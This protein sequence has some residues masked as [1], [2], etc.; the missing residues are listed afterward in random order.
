MVHIRLFFISLLFLLGSSSCAAEILTG[1]VVKVA[2]GDTF[3]LLVDGRT[4]YRIRLHGIDA[5]EIKGGQPFSRVA[6]QALADMVAG[7]LVAVEVRDTDR[8]GR[9]IGVVTTA[10]VA[11]VNL[12]ML[13][14]GL[15]WHYSRY[16]NTP[17]YRQAQKAARSRRLGLWADK[18]PINPQSWRKGVRH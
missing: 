12:A 13:Q 10:E 5:P 15:A 8:Y 9:Y 17:S 18:S 6:R 7:Q 2:D 11:D 16:D 14:A 1:K 3:T 4:Q